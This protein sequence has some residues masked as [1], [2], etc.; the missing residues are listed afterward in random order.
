MAKLHFKWQKFPIIVFISNPFSFQSRN[1]KKKTT[2]M[3]LFYRWKHFDANIY[4]LVIEFATLIDFGCWRLGRWKIILGH[5]LFLKLL[6]L[7]TF[8]INKSFRIFCVQF[9]L[10]GNFPWQLRVVSSKLLKYFFDCRKGKSNFKTSFIS[11]FRNKSYQRS[12]KE[13][14]SCV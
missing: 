10:F 6:N 4:E 9:T 2:A 14:I 1:S 5:K 11:F 13:F 3:K 7:K 12:W 8:T